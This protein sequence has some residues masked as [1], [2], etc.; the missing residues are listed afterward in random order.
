VRLGDGDGD[1]DGDGNGN[2]AFISPCH[3]ERAGG[4]R[5]VCGGDERSV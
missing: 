5:G 3:R 4:G 2:E 1:G